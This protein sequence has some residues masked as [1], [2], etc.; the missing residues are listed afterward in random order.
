MV[1]ATR[2][3][4]VVPRV[5]ALREVGA[6][7]GD[8][9]VGAVVVEAGGWS[10]AALFCTWVAANALIDASDVSVAAVAMARSST[11][12]RMSGERDDMSDTTTRRPRGHMR[13]G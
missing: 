10:G 2:P 11:A 13:R 7:V 3:V 1:V 4:T 6:G 9:V 8:A 5:V 12:E